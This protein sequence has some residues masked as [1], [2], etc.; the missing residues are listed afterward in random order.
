MN[1]V[2]S[3]P[4]T[5]RRL[6]S[7]SASIVPAAIIAV[8]VYLVMPSHGQ[9]DLVVGWS[10]IHPPGV[11]QVLVTSVIWVIA[12]STATVIAALPRRTDSRVRIFAGAMTAYGVVALFGALPLGSMS[13]AMTNVV[14]PEYRTGDGGGWSASVVVYSSVVAFT[15]AIAVLIVRRTQSLRLSA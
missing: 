13:M 6:L 5:M 12:G 10:R 14:G 15:L 3:R 1:P 8:G 7:V 11:V 9:G 2:V 4:A